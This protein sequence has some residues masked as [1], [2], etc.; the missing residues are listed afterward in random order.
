[1]QCYLSSW[2]LPWS[3]FWF[4]PGLPT[5]WLGRGRRGPVHHWGCY[6]MYCG[7]SLT[8]PG[9]HNVYH[10]GEKKKCIIMNFT[11]CDDKKMD[12]SISRCGDHRI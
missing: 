11:V 9:V 5:L 2:P 6:V 12:S 4:D 3:W 1:M 7:R 10:L 8:L